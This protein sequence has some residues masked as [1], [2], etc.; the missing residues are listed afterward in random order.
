MSMEQQIDAV[1]QWWADQLRHTPM[2]DNGDALQTIMM[3]TLASSIRRKHPVSDVQIEVF[4][5]VV[6]EELQ[7]PENSQ[8]LR[9]IAF[10]T[11]YQPDG[12]LQTALDAAAITDGESRLPVKTVTIIGDGEARVKNG[13][14]APIQVIYPHGS[15]QKTI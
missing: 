4:K 12:I 15:D 1:A 5:M 14:G 10:G 11:D 13:Y 3:T 9:G 2:H 7:K 8:Y 6:K